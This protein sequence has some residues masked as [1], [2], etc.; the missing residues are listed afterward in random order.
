M[1]QISEDANFL[2]K[3]NFM[4]YSLLLYI[5]IKPYKEF[6]A[7]ASTYEIEDEEI[8]EDKDEV[9]KVEGDEV[10][11]GKIEGD[12]VKNDKVANGKPKTT[13]KKKMVR[14][15]FAVHKP[16]SMMKKRKGTDRNLYHEE[17]KELA[18]VKRKLSDDIARH[19][20]RRLSQDNNTQ[21][22]TGQDSA[23]DDNQVLVFSER[24]KNK[25][26][27]YHV[28]NSNDINNMLFLDRDD[29]LGQTE[30]QNSNFSFKV[31]L[32]CLF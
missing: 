29:K 3:Q 9:N 2:S 30:S 17:Q 22:D 11:N 25:L 7:K 8:E 16:H 14:N 1:S 28:C 31:I 24:N 10:K 21:S 4:D 6:A 32:V 12:E 18:A 15:T 26:K 5:I 23:K 13:K 20:N 19:I 27:I